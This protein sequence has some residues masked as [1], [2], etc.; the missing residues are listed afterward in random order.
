MI[1]NDVVNNFITNKVI[2][3]YLLSK[4]FSALKLI[5]TDDSNDLDESADVVELDDVLYFCNNTRKHY[6][7]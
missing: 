2:G 5:L 1:I 3:G 4:K 7:D 6:S